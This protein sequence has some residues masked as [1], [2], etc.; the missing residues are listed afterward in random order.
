MTCHDRVVRTTNGD[1][2]WFAIDE[3]FYEGSSHETE[4]IVR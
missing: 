4:K 2:E 1:E 3:V